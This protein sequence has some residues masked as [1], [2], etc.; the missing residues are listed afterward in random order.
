[1]RFLKKLAS[2]WNRLSLILRIVLGL[3]AGSAAGLAFSETSNPEWQCLGLLGDLY[4][5]LLK[6]IAPVL[7]FVLVISAISCGGRAREKKGNIRNII[8]LYV[9]SSFCAAVFAVACSFVYR[10]TLPGLHPDPTL[11]SVETNLWKSISKVLSNV[12]SNPIAGLANGDYLPILFWACVLGG[13]LR[14]ASDQTKTAL[15]DV[16]DAV[17]GAVQLVISFAPFGVLGLIFTAISTSGLAIFVDYGKLII[18]LVIAILFVALVINPIIAAFCLRKNPYPL[19]F[20][21]LKYS[22]L[23]A[24][25]TRSSAA[26]IPVNLE[27]CKSL[28]LSE[29]DYSVTIPLR[30]SRHGRRIADADP[31]GLRDVWDSSGHSLVHRGRGRPDRR[32]SG[33]LRNSPQFVI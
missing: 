8:I 28:G 15:N 18:L 19:V 20:K 12:V 32:Y 4:I 13:G 7:V 31:T 23:N 5:G 2:D 24:F 27:L 11:A 33:L 6:A 9:T 10:V 22:G 21:C 26:N 17:T 1:M 14:K 16:A 30:D 3:L 29:E 25:F